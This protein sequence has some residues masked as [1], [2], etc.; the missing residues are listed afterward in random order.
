MY[1]SS[2]GSKDPITLILPYIRGDATDEEGS[3]SREWQLIKVYKC[4]H[5]LDVI[6]HWCIEVRILV[7]PRLRPAQGMLKESDVVLSSII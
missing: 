7:F 5:N 1:G 4:W 6:A 3:S 2:P